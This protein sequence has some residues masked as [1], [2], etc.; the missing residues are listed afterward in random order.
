VTQQRRGLQ[1]HAHAFTQHG[2]RLAR[3]VADPEDPFL[4][5]E[6][7]HTVA[8]MDIEDPSA[9]CRP[10][11]TYRSGMVVG[12]GAP[13]LVIEPWDRASARVADIL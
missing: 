7:L 4:G 9:S 3:G 10:F 13:M 1:G 6:A 11:S 12:E 8:T 2:M 5:W